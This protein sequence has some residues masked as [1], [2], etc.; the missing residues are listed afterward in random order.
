MMMMRS[1]FFPGAIVKRVY[2]MV[3][4][5]FF[6][7]VWACVYHCFTN[8]QEKIEYGRPIVLE[9]ALTGVPPLFLFFVD[10]ICES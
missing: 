2:Q 9:K 3:W 7:S 1:I 6:I 4:K 5:R 8:V 10:V